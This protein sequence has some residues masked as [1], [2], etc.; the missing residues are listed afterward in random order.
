[1]RIIGASILCYSIDPIL[2]KPYFIL[3]IDST[4][5]WSDFG[6]GRHKRESVMDTACREFVEETCGGYIDLEGSPP[7][8]RFV[9]ESDVRGC[10]MR[11]EF[12]AKFKFNFETLRRD[13]LRENTGYVTYVLRVP[14]QPTCLLD[15][16][17]HRYGQK[18]TVSHDYLEKHQLRYFSEKASK[19]IYLKRHFRKRF[20]KMA[21]FVVDLYSNRHRNSLTLRK[22]ECW[23]DARR[24]GPS[25]TTRV[26]MRSTPQDRVV[27]V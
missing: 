10:L 4:G 27:S 1:M 9:K 2:G 16:S 7:D 14:W 21:A 24:T 8:Y 17:T 23:S 20:N 6:G 18:D 19:N 15:W 22:S 3:G 25:K 5:R 11:R 12:V 26:G 13:G